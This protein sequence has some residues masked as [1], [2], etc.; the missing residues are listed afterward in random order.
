M[1]GDS[2]LFAGADAT[3]RVYRYDFVTGTLASLGTDMTPRPAADPK[4]S[5]NYVL[6]YDKAGGHV[7]EFTE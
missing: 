2:L 6:W 7:G 1:P 4:G 3:P 5:G